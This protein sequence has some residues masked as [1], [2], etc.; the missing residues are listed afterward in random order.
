[1]KFI[2]IAA[3]C[4]LTLAVFMSCSKGSDKK[5]ADAQENQIDAQQ[6]TAA[7]VAENDATKAWQQYKADKEVIIAENEAAIAGYKVKMTGANGKMTAKYNKKIEALELKNTE[8]KTKLADYKDDGKTTWE[9]FKMDFDKDM[10]KLGTD[11]KGIVGT[12]KK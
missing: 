12:D 9:Q 5:V 10:D 3:L 7:A 6:Q 2:I 8:L 4:V 1:M 11:I